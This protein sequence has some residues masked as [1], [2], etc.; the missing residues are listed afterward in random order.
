MT[1]SIKASVKA[2][3]AWLAAALGGD[4]VEADL[5]EKHRKMEKGPFPF[6]RATYWRWAETVGDVCPDL[7]SAPPVLAIGDTHVEN[8]GCWRDAEG[9][10]V[11]G[12]N[13][14]DDAAVMPYPLD[15]VRL[16]ASA[17]LARGDEGPDAGDICDAIL[18]GYRTGLEA[19][20]PFVLDRRHPWL[21]QAVRLPE[22]DREDFW[23]KYDQPDQPDQPSVVGRYRDRLLDGLPEPSAKVAVFPRQAGLGS[24]GRPRFVAR[25]EWRGG[26]VLREAKAVVLSAWTLARGGDPVMRI[27]DIAAGRF[28][29]VDPHY[30]VADG[31]V[32][33][34]LS[35]NSRKIEV[36]DSSEQLL[37]REMLTAM[38]WEIANCHMGDGGR[39][40]GLAAHVAALPDGWLRTHAKAAANQVEADWKAYS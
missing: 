22:A 6:L 15:L 9:R 25:A 16:A 39:A 27:G 7:M 14:F 34:R 36:K 29:A 20:T 11:W 2:Y 30:R 35:P 3:E 19:P 31:I 24:L 26:P 13:D 23:E 5:V 12:A 38:G 4:L 1:M 10:L 37:H 28:R 17:L 18:K 8:F 40:P 32:V 33:R 21:R